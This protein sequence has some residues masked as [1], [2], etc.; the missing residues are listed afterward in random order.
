[1]R[2]RE[3]KPGDEYV[4]MKLIHGLAAYEKA[5]EEVKNNPESLAKDLFESKLCEAIVLE[6]DESIIGFALY[7][8][9]YSTWRGP[10][11]YLEDL[12]VVPEKRGQNAGK[13]LFD[14]VVA[15]CKKRKF[16]RMDWQVL[17][18][19]EPAIEFY[20]KVNATLDSEWINGRLFFDYD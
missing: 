3:A 12:Y 15:I 2:V 1:M 14:Q 18:W 11:L 4:I 16:R 9:S 5:S 19:N 13:L 20:K 17:D 7:Y 10:C 6:E 8:T